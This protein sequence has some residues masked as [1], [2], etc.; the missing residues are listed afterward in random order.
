M[1]VARI[2]NEEGRRGEV[3]FGGVNGFYGYV[4]LM[5]DE[6]GMDLYEVSREAK[7]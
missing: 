1:M 6:I 7:E 4:A 2:S 5:Y 3:D